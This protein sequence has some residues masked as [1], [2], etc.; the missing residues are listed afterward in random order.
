MVFFIVSADHFNWP[1]TDTPQTTVNSNVNSSRAQSCASCF[2]LTFMLQILYQNAYLN[3]SGDSKPK[4][5]AVA[6]LGQQ[7][8]CKVKGVVSKTPTG[9]AST[10]NLNF[11]VGCTN[12][13]GKHKSANE[14]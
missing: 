10:Q 6:E 7:S 12:I 1:Y 8:C 5:G 13:R 9:I 3:Y 4:R 2:L 14:E 11:N